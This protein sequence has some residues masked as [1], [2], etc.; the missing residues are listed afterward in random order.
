[1]SSVPV[2]Q[3]KPSRLEAHHLALALG[4]S[5]TDLL[6]RS[7][8]LSKQKMEAR[9]AQRIRT[10][11][12]PYGPEYDAEI[13]RIRDEETAFVHR[14][15]DRESDRVLDLFRQIPLRLRAANSIW[16]TCADEYHARR[17]ELDYAISASWQL[18][19][20]LQY[21]VE[22]LPVNINRY[23][24]LVLQIETIIACTKSLRA[25]D[26]KRFGKFDDES[27][28][29]SLVT[30]LGQ[31][32]HTISA[33]YFGNANNNGNANYNNASNVNGVRPVGG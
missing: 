26:K 17:V 6:S 1:M 15:I 24:E 25:S 28:L 13:Q 9:I 4:R 3:R 16:P 33:T 18:H 14:M 20:E 30:E 29:Q 5:L 11:A 21:I 19:D 2:S 12:L 7:L 23:T 32:L 22:S 8:G 27:S 10:V 31:F